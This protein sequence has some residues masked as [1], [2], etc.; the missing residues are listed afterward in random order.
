MGNVRGINHVGL[1]VPNIDEATQFFKE[2][3][4]AKVAYDGLSYDDEPREGAEVER[5]LGLS[6]GAKIVKQRMIVIGNGPNIEMFEIKSSNQADPLELEDLG[7]NHI[8]LFVDDM[9]QAIKDAKS[10]GAKPLSEKHG[11]SR[12]EDSKGSSSV[13]V[14][15]PWCSLIELQAIPNGYYY[16]E[17]SESTVFIP[18]ETK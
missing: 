3:F 13:Y 5:Q 1:T 16:P 15:S 6:K 2:A 11:N 8:S 18:D 4:G 9:D 10:A 17:D 14:E 12:Y 7:Y